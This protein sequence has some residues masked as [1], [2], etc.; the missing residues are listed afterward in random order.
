MTW[1]QHRQ[2][3]PWDTD[4]LFD[5]D[6]AVQAL[7]AASICPGCPVQEECLEAGKGERFGVWGGLTFPQRKRLAR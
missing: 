7:A 3:G 5:E 1:H 4:S 6:P 2:C